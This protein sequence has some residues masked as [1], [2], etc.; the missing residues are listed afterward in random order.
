MRISKKMIRNKVQYLAYKKCEY[1]IT[2][3]ERAGLNSILTIYKDNTLILDR[4]LSNK[5]IMAYLEKIEGS[6]YYG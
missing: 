1:K 2:V 5:D 4:A 3:F 6:C